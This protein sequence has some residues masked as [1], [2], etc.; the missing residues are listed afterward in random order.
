MQGSSPQQGTSVVPGDWLS[1]RGTGVPLNFFLFHPVVAGWGSEPARQRRP[2]S[3]WCTGNGCELVR[4][5]LGAPQECV[6][7][8]TPPCYLRFTRTCETS[9]QSRTK[10]EVKAKQWFIDTGS[11]K[12]VFGCPQREPHDYFGVPS[13]LGFFFGKSELVRFA[14]RNVHFT[15]TSPSI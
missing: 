2:H 12:S 8:N 3:A 4:K 7:K 9:V 11:P 5:T 10:G 1:P 14:F 6:R 13:Q 15:V